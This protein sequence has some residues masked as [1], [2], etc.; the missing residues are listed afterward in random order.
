MLYIYEGSESQFDEHNHS[1]KNPLQTQDQKEYSY[2]DIK[3]IA[4]EWTAEVM[5]DICIANGLNLISLIK[6]IIIK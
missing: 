4:F 1:R 5:Y 6:S 3:F 2:R